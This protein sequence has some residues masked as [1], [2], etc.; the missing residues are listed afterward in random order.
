M[1]ANMWGNTIESTIERCGERVE[2]LSFA[3]R[4]FDENR[5]LA[6]GTWKMGWEDA[7]EL[8]QKVTAERKAVLIAWSLGSF[9][10]LGLAA[11]QSSR[12]ASIILVEPAYNISS[13]LG[14]GLFP[15]LRGVLSSTILG[16]LPGLQSWGA[17][18]FLRWAFA[19]QTPLATT[20]TEAVAELLKEAG[21]QVTLRKVNGCNH[22]M[23]LQRVGSETIVDE[24]YKAVS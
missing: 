20:S 2:I 17:T 15:M 23:P 19:S 12:I 6:P 24:I 4:G 11:T 1:A 8:L 5:V 10:A 18:S 21:I 22:L 14:P 9:I 16:G 7:T 3:R 13:Y